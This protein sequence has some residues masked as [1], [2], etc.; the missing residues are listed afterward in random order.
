VLDPFELLWQVLFGLCIFDEESGPVRPLVRNLVSIPL[1]I[2]RKRS[3]SFSCSPILRQSVRV[4]KH[5]SILQRIIIVDLK[6]ILFLHLIHNVLVLKPRVVPEVIILPMLHR[7]T[8]FLV[9]LGLH[10]PI[11]KLVSQLALLQEI[12]RDFILLLNPLLS[13]G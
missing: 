13:F 8:N 2:F 11:L 1:S 10:Q 7:D 3:L 4:K 5:L 9:V 6:S 12:I